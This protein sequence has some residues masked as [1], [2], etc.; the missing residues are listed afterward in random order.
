MIRDREIRRSI[1]I[2][3][4][5]DDMIGI[6]AGPFQVARDL[7]KIRLGKAMSL[8]TAR[9]KVTS[10]VEFVSDSSIHYTIDGDMHTSDGPVV[11]ETG[12]RLEI[13]LK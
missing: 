8:D 9:S 13:I 10:R 11:L 1:A 5:Q 3:V 4:A 12:P 6:Q 7:P 2:Q